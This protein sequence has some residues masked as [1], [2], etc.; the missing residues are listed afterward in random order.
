MFD[1]RLNSL[2]LSGYLHC[3]IKPANFIVCAD[4]DA[5]KS[6]KRRSRRFA[7]NARN[8]KL[9]L[10][11]FGEG[12]RKSEIQGIIAGT[13]WYMAPEMR[14]YG[15]PSIQSEVYSTGVSMIEIWYGE[16]WDG[17]RSAEACLAD[18]ITNISAYVSYSHVQ[19]VPLQ[20]H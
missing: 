11:D 19:C 18:A 12:G 7:S 8:I 20:Q 5:I 10:I 14:D 4:D 1:V 13:D 15:T 2:V 9:K 16:L 3:D 6:P 17:T